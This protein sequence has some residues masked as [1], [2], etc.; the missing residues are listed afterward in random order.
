MGPQNLRKCSKMSSPDR[1][2]HDPVAAYDRIAPGFARLAEQRRPYLDRIDQLVLSEMP[3]ESSS[4]LEV[5]SGDGA[6]D[7]SIP[8]DRGSAEPE[9]LYP[10][11]TRPHHTFLD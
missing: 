2:Y 9:L 11:L 4:L 10:R 1:I 8:H 7:R 6:R 3:P 5:G